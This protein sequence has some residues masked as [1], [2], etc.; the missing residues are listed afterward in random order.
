M[1]YLRDKYAS[2]YGMVPVDIAVE[3]EQEAG[4][5]GKKARARRAERRESREQF[6]LE[7]IKA[8]AEGRALVAGQ[9]GGLAGLGAGLGNV[10]KGIFGGGGGE[11]PV[12]QFNDPGAAGA[13]PYAPAP[14]NNNRK[15]IIIGLIVVVVVIAVIVIVKRKK[16]KG[17]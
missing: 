1:S 6:K 14:E 3:T 4:F 15:V 12:E 17:K 2:R 13:G 8:K 16:S 7:K 11:A 5:F 9:G 10:V